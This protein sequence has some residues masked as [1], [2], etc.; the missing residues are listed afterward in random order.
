MKNYR[1]LTALLL[2]AI[3]LFSTAF[4]TIALAA[5]SL[6]TYNAE[7]PVFYDF[8]KAAPQPLPFEIEDVLVPASTAWTNLVAGEA[9]AQLRTATYK[10]A[11]GV[12]EIDS[13]QIA[14]AY[15]AMQGIFTGSMAVNG[16]SNTAFEMATPNRII[17]E[18]GYIKKEILEAV[19]GRNI[20]NGEVVVDSATGTAFKVAGETAFASSPMFSA[21]EELGAM[22]RA[23]SGT[24][25]V[26][27]PQVHELLEDFELGGKDGETVELTL[28]NITAFAKNVENNAILPNGQTIKNLSDISAAPVVPMSTAVPLAT[29]FEYVD[30]WLGFEFDTTPLS[31]YKADG[32]GG[33]TLQV[34]GGVAIAKPEL[35][36]RYSAFSGYEFAL[37]LA[38]ECYLEITLQA[39]INQEVYIPLFGIDIPFGVGSVTGGVFLVVGIN[40]DFRLHIMAGEY[41]NTT[42]G[43]RGGTFC[44]VPTSV[45]PIF[46]HT[47]ETRGDASLS[48][49]INAYVKIGPEAKVRIFGLDL[50]GAGAYLGAGVSVEILDD[51]ANLDVRLY[52]IFN[53]FI[54]VIGKRCNLIN[55]NPTIIR[56]K[57]VNLDGYKLEV[58]DCYIAPGRVGGRF[59]K[60]T[61]VNGKFGLV[62]PDE[63]VKY[64]IRIEKGGNPN[65]VEYHPIDENWLETNNA[66]EF[67]IGDG[68]GNFMDLGY[69]YGPFGN[70]EDGSINGIKNLSNN[71]EIIIEFILPR[72]T[73]VRESEHFSPKLPFK[74]VVL[75]TADSFNDFVI[76]YVA[77]QQLK[78]W[79]TD[80]QLPVEERCDSVYPPKDTLVYITPMR[81]VAENMYIDGELYGN[82]HEWKGAYS[83]TAMA[84]T[85]ELGKF[86][87]RIPYAKLI[88]LF[89]GN[90][91]SKNYSTDGPNAG[92]ANYGWHIT[93]H[94]PIIEKLSH[95]Y[96]NLSDYYADY[97]WI[98]E[99]W[100]PC[101]DI[102]IRYKDSSLDPVEYNYLPEMPPFYYN[103][104]VYPVEGTFTKT[105]EGNKVVDRMDYDEY[106]WIVNPA[107][108]RV[109]T[110]KEFF[111]GMAQVYSRV[112]SDNYVNLSGL[113]RDQLWKNLNDNNYKLVRTKD[114]DGNTTTMF[115]Q[116]VTVEWV[117]QAHPNPVKINSVSLDGPGF[118]TTAGGTFNVYAEGLL[119]A[120]YLEGAPAGVTINKNTGLITVAPGMAAGSYPFT[121][122][123]VQEYR[124]SIIDLHMM[125]NYDLHIPD[126][127]YYGHDPVPPD[128][129]D[130]T[131]TIKMVPPVIQPKEQTSHYYTFM[132]DVNDDELVVPIYTIAGDQPITWSVE[133][134]DRFTPKPDFVSIDP[135][136]GILRIAPSSGTP[137]GRYLFN[138]SAKNDGGPDYVNCEVWVSDGDNQVPP[139][140]IEF[141]P[142]NYTIQQGSALQA[143]YALG[144]NEPITVSVAAV[145]GAG[146]TVSGF[147]VDEASQTVLVPNSLATGR[148]IVTA[149]AENEGGTSTA[150][151]TLEVT[152]AP[153]EITPPVITFGNARYTAQQGTAFQTA[154]TLTGTEPITVTVAA[155]NERG[156]AISGFT[157]NMT[158]KTV[159]APA[160]LAAGTYIVTATATNGAG[161]ST[162]R[163]TLEVTTAPVETKPPAITFGNSRYT[164]K[165]GT[166]FQATY[167]LT[168]TE[169]ITVTVAATNERGTTA[170]GF[171]VNAATREVVASDKVASGTYTVTATAKN[172][173]GES[174]ATF[175]LL[176]TEARTAPVIAEANHG[177][178]F[179]VTA[180]G[181][182]LNVPVSATGSAPIT[183][184]LEASDKMQLPIFIEINASTGVLTTTARAIQGTYYFVIK[185]ANDVGADTRQCTLYVSEAKTAPAFI[186]E[187]HNYQ[188]SVPPMR[189]EPT[190]VQINVTG[191]TPITYS[192]EQYKDAIPRGVSI[193]TSTGVLTIGTSV[194]TGEYHFNI[195]ASNDA[196]SATQLCSLTVSRIEIQLLNFDPQAS[197]FEA[198]SI[199][200]L[201]AATTSIIPLSSASGQKQELGT[202][203]SVAGTVGDME[204][205]GS[206]QMTSNL[207]NAQGLLKRAENHLAV[208][209]W[210]NMMVEASLGSSFK[211]QLAKYSL[212]PLNTATVR[213][214]D[215][216]DV[217]TNDRDTVNGTE[218]VYWDSAV[219]IDIRKSEYI[220][221]HGYVP[222]SLDDVYF[223]EVNTGTVLSEVYWYGD[224]YHALGRND[225]WGKTVEDASPPKPEFYWSA[226]M[227]DNIGKIFDIGIFDMPAT[228]GWN[229]VGVGDFY[230]T[231]T[232]TS[233]KP[234]RGP[235]TGSDG[236][237]MGVT[238]WQT[239]GI[240]EHLTEM[241]A[242]KNVPYTVTLNDETGNYVPIDYFIALDGNKAMSLTFE[243]KG[244]NITFAGKDLTGYEAWE[245]LYN[246]GYSSG[247]SMKQQIL[248]ATGISEEEYLSSDIGALFD[249]GMV[250]A[251]GLQEGEHFTYSFLHHGELPG[252][253][254][255]D[256][257]TTISEGATVNVYKYDAGTGSFTLIAKSLKVGESGVVSYRNNTMSDYIITTETIA[258][259]L[260]PGGTAV[261][262][263]WIIIAAVILLAA[264]AVVFIVLR[265]KVGESFA[266]GLMKWIQREERR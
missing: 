245:P 182:G 233:D 226:G 175:T 151:F 250:D 154:Y 112:D 191:S 259:A 225:V 190:E 87:T 228:S 209:E 42:M 77:Q 8:D 22:A 84:A 13:A 180:G 106:I 14:A 183:W 71:D 187:K 135:V 232:E 25:S 65:D 113:N 144:G 139:P 33:V 134:R 179:E 109:I 39:N 213:W 75:T 96:Y 249:D 90:S 152:A 102:V 132:V 251:A 255:F 1:N 70:N 61:T 137:A 261:W 163:F 221:T 161:T 85:D 4:P 20:E 32:S 227:L 129:R 21:T 200:L 206:W 181:Q 150:T 184:S 198:P 18:G 66:G 67:F 27:T 12:I 162:A 256:I 178:A 58:D 38:Q 195:K 235:W 64:R 43:A 174:S 60:E 141:I 142:S 201:S 214:N 160:S 211:D 264:G 148:Y 241:E 95:D 237:K 168:G 169:P 9:P 118:L 220:E 238:K 199:S 91:N 231:M 153:A 28:G 24:Y 176:V 63:S 101:F 177:Y 68:L 62:P 46:R 69:N 164:M 31:G 76:G 88:A 215:P 116:R 158:S 99:R 258:G 122:V 107:G 6:G 111:Y 171:T 173:A 78:N 138:I 29:D 159:R 117:W 35:T 59:M 100:I 73:L 239:L 266:A 121:I 143:P 48:G 125:E 80:W 15:T 196:G 194:A 119:P 155:A 44:C 89:T 185:A 52:G 105:T 51:G 40:G 244:Y 103:R 216:K 207:E 53:V 189:R 166:F 265:K 7:R 34:S 192:L 223:P 204:Q 55:F 127:E 165:Q 248:N 126:Y 94:T 156:A 83:F 262:W 157:V 93:D 86:D 260:T 217:Y 108:T 82:Y 219:K 170:S 133:D 263:L 41:T 114:K 240:G 5:D 247:T 203:S 208:V 193:N 253:A 188:F 146:A 229:S 10:L 186:Q 98:K 30:K 79:K 45:R 50:I 131:L 140:R 37:T 145:N 252:M 92:I 236:Y 81:K 17:S 230:K 2:T 56:K 72:S 49:K 3:M 57:Q 54:T 257:K 97:S 167:T 202:L 123:A 19:V 120:Y 23:L 172:S 149:T 110:D 11:D 124:G 254:T 212:M 210:Q 224:L 147:T 218:Y 242:L 26:V 234:V 130:F 243:Q 205:A 47:T 222:S 197:N 16:T 74:D 36:A 128:K 246:F 104:E 115:S 136:T